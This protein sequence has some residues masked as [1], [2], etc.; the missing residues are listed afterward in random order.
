[1]ADIFIS[2][3]SERR[4]AAEHFAEVLKRYG[5]S[6]W[7]D[8]ELAM[9]EDFAA[10][11]EHEIREAKALL[12]LWCSRSVVSPWVREEVHLARELGILVPVKIENCQ[13]P[14]DSQ[15]VPAIELSAWD[16]GPRASALDPLIDA[17]EKVTGRRTVLARKSL[18]EYEDEWWRLG[19]P[20]PRAFAL[21]TALEEPETKRFGLK[22]P[23]PALPAPAPSPPVAKRFGRKPPPPASPVPAPMPAERLAGRDWERF[24]IGDSYDASSIEAYIK[25]YEVS[26]PRWARRAKK[27]LAVIKA[28]LREKAAAERARHARYRA[29]GR[30][31]VATP[32]TRPAGLEWFLPGAG[33][34]E[35]FKDAEFAPEMVAVPAG[36]FWMGSKDG[37]GNGDERPRHKVTIAEPFAVG[38]FAVTF[39]EWDAARAAGGVSHKPS[40]QIGGRGRRRPVIDVSWDDARAYVKWLSFTTVQ[41]YRLLSEA[42]WEYCCRAG[43]ETQ[44]WWG[45]GIS[46]EQAS[47]DGNYAF[48]KGAKDNQKLAPVNSFRPNPWG[49]Y[50]VHGNVWEWCADCW[51]GNYRDA[52]ADGSAWTAGDSQY[53]VLRGGSW[54]GGPDTLRSARRIVNSRDDRF[55]DVGFR[56]ARTLSPYSLTL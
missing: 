29:E 41:P 12:V 49:L 21:K 14:I 36:E 2:H 11:I 30:I 16:G 25:Q 40:G 9:G 55:Q 39:D 1:M 56:V 26:E 51:H 4:A 54:G 8:Y 5:Y 43:T 3:K 17:L 44:F 33:R 52:P 34:T 7:F 31:R 32:I 50:Q 15:L 18:R 22:P 42:E 6:V 37:E 45:D 48:G 13:I 19:S 23:P 10:R 28:A 38:R 35:C 27:R 53:R 20:R 46:R 24:H 47:Y